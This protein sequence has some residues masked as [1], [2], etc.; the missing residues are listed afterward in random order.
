[1]FHQCFTCDSPVFHQCFTSVSPVFQQYLTIDLPV[2][3]QCFTIVSPMFHQCFNSV[4]PAFHQCFMNFFTPVLLN[5]HD[6][7]HLAPSRSCCTSRNFYFQQDYIHPP[8]PTPL[9]PK[10][11]TI[12]FFLDPMFGNSVLPKRGPT[13]PSLLVNSTH[14][15]NFPY[16][17]INISY[18]SF[19]LFFY[20]LISLHF[21]A[22]LM[23][24]M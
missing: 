17:A 19:F 14:F 10:K 11:E 13:R 16:H 20:K 3:Y 7:D 24:T 21:H 15:I 23:N 22:R 4:S 1:M 18:S 9:S 8:S 2:I 5:L 6:F 12:K